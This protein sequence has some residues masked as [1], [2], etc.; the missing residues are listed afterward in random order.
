[1]QYVD[2]NSLARR[3]VI[4]GV[5]L[6]SSIVI[7]NLPGRTWAGAATGQAGTAAQTTK[8][9]PSAATHGVDGL[10]AHLH[11]KFQITPA[12]ENLFQKLADVMK[13]NAETMSVL[14]KKRAEGAKTS[15]AVDDLK[16]YSEISEAHAA[17]TRKM[18]PVFQALYDSLSDAQKKAADDEFREHYAQHHHQKH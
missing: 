1:M 7:A 13:E 9:T 11:D 18:I 10:I 3:L 12:Q 2:R 14:A 16:S 17:G 5:I 15:T 4:T 8:T 6:M